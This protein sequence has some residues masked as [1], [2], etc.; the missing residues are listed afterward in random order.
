MIAKAF[1]IFALLLLTSFAVAKEEKIIELYLQQGMNVSAEDIAYAHSKNYVFNTYF[2]DSLKMFEKKVVQDLNEKFKRYLTLALKNE[3]FLK[4]DKKHQEDVLVRLFEKNN[5]DIQEYGKK[6]ITPDDI[7]NIQQAFDVSRLAKEKGIT[8][9]D[10]PAF[11]INN[12][13]YKHSLDI[14]SVIEGFK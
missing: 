7:I 1:S 3:A 2:I 6:L 12:K 14:K 9:S 10:T 4:L 13:V 5:G 11:I 8:V